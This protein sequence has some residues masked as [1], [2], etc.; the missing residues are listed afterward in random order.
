MS[1]T[2]PEDTIATFNAIANILLRCFVITVGA[3]LFT[4]LV[5]F[6]LGDVIFSIYSQLMEISRKEFDL[7]FLY[8]MTFLKALNILFFGIPFVAIKWY[9]RGNK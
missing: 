2:L 6:I 7:F 3:M 9:L 8:T 1:D 4:W 5:V